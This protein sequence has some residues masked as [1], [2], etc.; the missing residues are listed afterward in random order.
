MVL[1]TQR[2][3]ARKSCSTHTAFAIAGGCESRHVGLPQPVFQPATSITSLTAKHNPSS[4]PLPVGGS[5]N[6]L[7]KA[8]LCA[9]LIEEHFI[10]GPLDGNWAIRELSSGNDGFQ[11][12][13][14]CAPISRRARS[15]RSDS[16]DDRETKAPSACSKH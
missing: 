13:T 6:A 16:H 12:V 15:A 9:T 8:L 14:P 11:A 2:A 3:P 1:P 5:S 10:P 4:M 7:R